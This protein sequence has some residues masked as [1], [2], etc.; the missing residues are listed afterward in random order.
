MACCAALTDSPLVVADGC[1]DGA[2]RSECRRAKASAAQPNGSA[3][4]PSPREFHQ[5]EMALSREANPGEIAALAVRAAAGWPIELAGLRIRG[6][7]EPTAGTVVVTVDVAAAAWLGDDAT[8]AT[9]TLTLAE[10]SEA[11]SAARAETGSGAFR[12]VGTDTDG[13]DAAGA[14]DESALRCCLAADPGG[15]TA[16]RLAAGCDRVE[17]AA[18]PV[19]AVDAPESAADTEASPVSASATPVAGT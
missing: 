18:L 9:F 2:V 13:I 17:P 7:A 4:V 16:D 10:G 6:A 3:A 5:D 8:D 12:R 19:G 14:I 1:A 11:I 15:D